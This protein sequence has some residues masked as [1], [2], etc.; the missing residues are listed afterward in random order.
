VEAALVIVD[1]PDPLEPSFW[2]ASAEVE[3]TDGAVVVASPQAIA[4]AA[5]ASTASR[6]VFRERQMATQ[7][8]DMAR[9]GPTPT[10]RRWLLCKAVRVPGMQEFD[11]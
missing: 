1:L 11:L 9:M 2:R 3:R 6:V 4:K 10:G 8:F 5:A 7:K